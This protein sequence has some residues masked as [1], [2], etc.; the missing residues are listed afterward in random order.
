M[1]DKIDLL[2]YIPKLLK[3]PKSKNELA[4]E[5]STHDNYIMISYYNPVWNSRDKSNREYSLTISRFINRTSETF[6]VLGLLQAEMGKTNNGLLNFSNCEYKLINKI[7][8]W[9]DKELEF[10]PEKWKWYIKINLREPPDSE[11]RKQ[12]EEK[13]IN[14]WLNKT[15]VLVE[16]SYPKSVVYVKETKNQKLKRGNYGTLTIERKVNLFSQIIKN[17][18]KKVA[19]DIINFDIELIKAY[20]RGILAGEACVEKSLEDKK[21]RI[22]LT[23][24]EKTERDIYKKCLEKLGIESKQ[25]KNYKDII[26]S[27]RKNNV[28]L[29]KQKLMCLSPSKYNRF[30]YMMKLYPNIN[31]E[32]GYFSGKR[33]PHNK[34]PLNKIESI[35]QL[36]KE[37]PSW[38]C[39]KI[40]KEAGVS[41]IKVARVRKE[42]N[43]VKRLNKTPQEKISEIINIHNKNPSLYAY[44]IAKL[45]GVHKQVVERAR[46]KYGLIRAKKILLI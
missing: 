8:K 26:I 30:L 18:V 22:H 31:K 40:A 4:L 24:V 11:I 37:N 27:K 41:T 21:Y 23:S 38:S 14:H 36:C 6:E 29:L 3:T 2:N 32:T 43:L 12:L 9:F 45:V 46:R 34:I 33:E 20:M 19:K 39:R 15:K 25:Y 44:E 42:N 13:L 10:G 17:F 35:I 7:M 16:N 28:E 5:I 1:A